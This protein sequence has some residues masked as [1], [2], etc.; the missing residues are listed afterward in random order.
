MNVTLSLAA[1]GLL[2]VAAAQKRG[3]EHLVQLTV[4]SDL[5]DDLSRIPTDPTSDYGELIQRAGVSEGPDPGSIKVVNL[6]TGKQVACAVN[7][8]FT[9]AD[10]GPV[11]WV[12]KKPVHKVYEIRFRTAHRRGS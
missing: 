3:P 10:A 7:E 2:R 9:G 1:I 4:N 8:D 12:S 5:A 11:E 6:A